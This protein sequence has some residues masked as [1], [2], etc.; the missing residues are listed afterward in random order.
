MREALFMQVE[1][2]LARGL[3]GLA[4]GLISVGMLT[5][6]VQADEVRCELP[7]GKRLEALDDEA[8]RDAFGMRM[9]SL[10]EDNNQHAFLSTLIL[11]I[12]K[13]NL[14]DP[15][16]LSISEQLLNWDMNIHGASI[17]TDSDGLTVRIIDEA[18]GIDVSMPMPNSIGLVE[19]RLYIGSRSDNCLGRLSMEN[20]RQSGTVTIRASFKQHSE[21]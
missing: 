11:A 16:V 2:L 15:E 18:S 9:V 8:L 12:V 19:G 14:N 17:D 10:E 4:V 6:P 5:A 21:Q 20:I 7:S 13:K 3:W 1:S